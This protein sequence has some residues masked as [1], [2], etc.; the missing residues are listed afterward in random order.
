MP[1][2]KELNAIYITATKY[3]DIIVT[4]DLPY[5]EASYFS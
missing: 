3:D 1:A 4:H 2:T 5:K